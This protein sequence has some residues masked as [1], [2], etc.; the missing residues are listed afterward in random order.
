MTG[1][2][3]IFENIGKSQVRALKAFIGNI[4][5]FIS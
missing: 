1:I 5:A 4:F 2:Y 3:Y